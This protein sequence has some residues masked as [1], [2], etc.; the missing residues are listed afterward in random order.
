[1]HTQTCLLRFAPLA[2]TAAV[3]G[4]IIAPAG[5][6]VPAAKAHRKC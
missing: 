6:A 1:M 3:L 4:A 5:T 2:A